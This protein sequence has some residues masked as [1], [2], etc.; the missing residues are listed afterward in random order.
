LVIDG[1]SGGVSSYA[2]SNEAY[3]EQEL[4][5]AVQLAGFENVERF[6]SLSGKAVAGEQDLP[7]VVARK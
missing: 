2:L 3:T 4:T 1:Q 7:G 6:L 5:K